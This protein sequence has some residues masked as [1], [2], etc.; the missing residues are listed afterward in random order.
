M[1]GY[2][3][4]E[5]FKTS[6]KCV[7]SMGYMRS[8]S[9]E[10]PREKLQLSG[11]S[12]LSNAELIQLILGSGTARISVGKLARSVARLLGNPAH[13][14][15]L[16][17]LQAVP[18]VGNA[19]ASQVIAAI[20]IGSRLGSSRSP[21]PSIVYDTLFKGLVKA[22]QPHVSYV[23]VDGAGNCIN[24]YSEKRRSSEHISL[25]VKRIVRTAIRD[26]AAGCVL[27]IHGSDDDT[28][29]GMEDIRLAHESRK[30]LEAAALRLVDALIVTPSGTHSLISHQLPKGEPS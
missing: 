2:F 30:A 21:R 28:P 11:V 29:P 24:L 17:A 4:L 3:L 9:Y 20:E 13:P 7:R 12:S 5:K 14:I 23:T 19:K 22:A 27:G 16:E 10:R 15:T 26:G 6:S 25:L 8:I 18:G 1:R